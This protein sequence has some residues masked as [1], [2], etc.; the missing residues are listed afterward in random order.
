MRRRAS[1]S[2]WVVLGSAA[3]AAAGAGIAWL[4]RTQP[5]RVARLLGH[6]GLALISV[7]TRSPAIAI[8]L[9]DGPHETLT[10]EVLEVL[11]R[12]G[13][14]ATFFFL[15]SAV[16]S[17]PDVVAATS[18]PGTR[19]AT[20]GGWTALPCSCLA[21]PSAATAGARLRPLGR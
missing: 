14:R 17:N 5:P 11:E 13:A 10:T 7:P 21:R 19:S 12:H 4:T 1:A 3:A 20:T 16:A 8:T 6:Q 18:R 15:G 2:R 9:D